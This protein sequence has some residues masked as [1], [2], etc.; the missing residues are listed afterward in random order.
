MENKATGVKLTWKKV[1]D[2]TG[3][4]V[5]R[6]NSGSK[7]W[8]KIKIV[9]GASKTTYTDS[10]VKSKHGTVYS[11]RIESYKSVNGQTAKAVSKEK[12]ILRLTAPTEVKDCEPEGKKAFSNVEKAEED[13]RLS[14]SV[15]YRQDFCK[16]DKDDKYS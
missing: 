13:F 11:Y 8:K 14:N 1:S 9:K 16:R 7:S 2:A 10:T 4:V 5:Y 6:K 12:K 15:F 3:Y